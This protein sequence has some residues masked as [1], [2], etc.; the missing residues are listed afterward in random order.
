MAWATS[1][2]LAATSDHRCRWIPRLF[3][4]GSH[5]RLRDPPR[6]HAVV[7]GRSLGQC[8][9]PAQVL[10]SPRAGPKRSSLQGSG[11]RQLGTLGTYHGRVPRSLPHRLR[12]G[13]ASSPW[14][15]CSLRARSV[16]SSWLAIRRLCGARPRDQE[17]CSKVA[18]R[19]LTI[20]SSRRAYGTRLTSNV[21]LLE[22]H[23]I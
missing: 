10:R 17:L 14:Y 22:T 15:T 19:G 3:T 4:L 16:V 18:Q 7:G 12:P 8:H 1:S 23:I 20:R 5:Q 2:G 13:C 9:R 11:S 21:S 6:R